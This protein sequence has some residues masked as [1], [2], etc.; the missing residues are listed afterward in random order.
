MNCI[1]VD[2]DELSTRLLQ[3]MLQQAGSIE[4]L[5]SFMNPVDALHY[6]KKNR[7]DLVFLDIEMPDLNGYELLRN[8]EDP[9]MVIVTSSH[10]DKAVEAFEFDILD[11]LLKPVTSA[12]FQRAVGRAEKKFINRF[13][14]LPNEIY[15]RSESK[16]VRLPYDEIMYVEALADYV[17]VVT[18]DAKYIVH[19]TMKGI[20]ERLPEEKFIRIHRSFILNLDAIESI[21]NQFVVSNKRHIPIGASYRET[22]LSRLNML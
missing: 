22:F 5:G 8:L 13:K 16:I 19:S 21:E 4:L 18:A 12:A 20:Q 14:K 10:R 9:P 6:L 2:D 11:F 7:V 17:T 3:H 1:I 15:V